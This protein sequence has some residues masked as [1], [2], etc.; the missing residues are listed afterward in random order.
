MPKLIPGRNGG[1]LINSLPGESGNPKGRPKSPKSL[2]DALNAIKNSD[3]EIT[4]KKFKIIK[5]KEGNEKVVVKI[6]N[7]EK[8]ALVW[9]DQALKNPRFAEIVNKITG[10]YAPV[11]GKIS[12]TKGSIYDDINYKALSNEQLDQLEKIV[13]ISQNATRDPENLGRE[14]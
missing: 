8:L 9:I 12:Y 5:D 1:T 7:A 13:T 4:F 11:E 14:S 3:G 6:P 10:D 2:R